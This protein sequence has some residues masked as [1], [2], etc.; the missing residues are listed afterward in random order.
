MLSRTRNRNRTTSEPSAIEP[1]QPPSSTP[2]E[3]EVRPPVVE[4]PPAADLTSKDHRIL[5][6]LGRSQA[7]IEFEPDGTI[8]TAN[9]NFLV[10]LGYSL[11]EIKGKHHRIFVDP[12]EAQAPE[13]QLF[14]AALANG[15]FQTA[16]YRRVAKDGSDVWIQAT[17]NPVLDEAGRVERVVKFATDITGQI[18]AQREIQDRTQA[19]I[20]FTP[21]GTIVNANELFLGTVGYSLEQIKGK[22]HRMF[23][24]PGEAD[25]PEYAQFWP[26][27]ARGEFLQGE[28]RRVDARGNELW[29]RGAYSPVIGPDGQVT[30]VQ[31]GVAN[32][33]DEVQNRQEATRVGEQIAGAVTEFTHAIQEIAGTVSRTATLAGEAETGVAGATSHIESLQATSDRIGSVIDIIKGLSGQTNILALNA[34]IEA[35]RAGEAGRGFAVVANQVKELAGQTSLSAN[36]IDEIIKAI[37]VEIRDAVAAVEAIAVSVVEVSNMTG[38]VAAAVEEQSALMGQLDNAA[39]ELLAISR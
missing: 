2:V 11:D 39:N 29:L 19:V 25:T 6:S 8:I 7:I 26:S 17:Y 31:K 3:T 36:D 24:P 12:V 9:D 28:F 32:I 16:Q 27:L 10:T 20:E 38:T 35:A 23:M 30:G 4:A 5:E 14:W 22:H 37:Q 33:T 21:D 15:T 18:L 13:Y 1:V 34:T